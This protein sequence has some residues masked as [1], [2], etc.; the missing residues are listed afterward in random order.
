MK[1]LYIAMDWFWIKAR[2]Q[3]LAI[4]L[5]EQHQVDYYC[6]R[7]WRGAQQ[8]NYSDQIKT[9]DGQLFYNENLKIIRKRY[10]PGQSK[11]VVQ[12]LN[13]WLFIHHELKKLQ[14]E[15]NYDCVFVTAP[16]H[17]TYLPDEIQNKVPIYY[18]CMDDYSEFF[19]NQA[20]KQRMLKYETELVSLAKH[21]FA[22]SDY[23][24][25]LLLK[26]NQISDE[27]ILVVQNGVETKDFQNIVVTDSTTVIPE[28]KGYKGVIGYVGTV[29]SWFDIQSV[30]DAALQL[31]EYL[32]YFAGPQEVVFENVPD[33]VLFVGPVPYTK[34][35]NLMA[36]FDVAT[37]PFLVTDLIKAVNPV[38]IYEYLAAG[39]PVVAVDYPE[40]Q[41]FGNII[42][43]YK[44]NQAGSFTAAI[45]AV[46]ATD[47]NQNQAKRRE[48][49]IE[50]DWHHRASQ[51]L[52]VLD[53]K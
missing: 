20:D 35:P 1:I 13:N 27:K 2:P 25:Q 10:L 17:V 49:A 12:Q 37:M 38:K 14:N 51:M 30:T 48:Y 18:D 22:S 39:T 34:V 21:V 26:R 41:K 29:G 24:K 45:K 32:F 33:N 36:S 42:T 50:N 6:I 3:Q 5:S 46:L 43:N 40:T 4:A 52:L 53:K 16:P 8:N 31:P 47:Q 28:A 19:P 44:F 7:G 23:L 9:I 11:A 15:N